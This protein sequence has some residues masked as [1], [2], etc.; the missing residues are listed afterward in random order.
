VQEIWTEG[1]VDDMNGNENENHSSVSKAQTL[2]EIGDFWD[3]HSLA[4]F[5]DRTHE[6]GFEVRARRQRRVTP[7]P[8]AYQRIQEQASARGIAADTLVKIW[9]VERL[10][11]AAG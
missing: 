7:E 5:W 2:E 10:R 9:L 6:V 1:N 3:E 4:D 8:D 11:Q